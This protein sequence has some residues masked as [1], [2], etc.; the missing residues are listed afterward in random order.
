MAITRVGGTNGGAA[1]AGAVTLTLPGGM[2]VDDLI[3]V[4]YGNG[5]NDA[6]NPTL[7]M[8]TAGYTNLLGSTLHGNNATNGDGSLAIFYKFH[9][10]SDTTAVCAA[11]G[12]GTDSASAAALQVF[13]GVSK[14]TPFEVTSTTATGT[15]GGDPNPPS[16]SSFTEAD[17]TVVI[18]GCVASATSPLTLTA[19][20]NYTTN[21]QNGT[22]TDTFSAST[23]LAYRLSGAADPEDPGVFTDSGTGGG[24][25]A[26]TMVLRP[27]R[28]TAQSIDATTTLT[29]AL[30]RA[31]GHSV[32]IAATTTL[33]TAL[34][35]S[36]GK[37]VAAASTLTAGLTATFVPGIPPVPKPI[38]EVGRRVFDSSYA[39]DETGVR[40]FGNGKNKVTGVGV[41]VFGPPTQ[42]IDVTTTISPSIAA[43]KIPALVGWEGFDHSVKTASATANL[44]TKLW[45]TVNDVGGVITFVTGRDGV[46]KAVQL[47]VNGTNT[48]EMRRNLAVGSTSLVVSMYVKLVGGVAPTGASLRVFQATCDSVGLLSIT[49][50]GFLVAAYSTG[51]G[52]H[53]SS[54]GFDMR[55]GNWHRVDAYYNTSPA[56]HTVDWYVDG[57]A[58]DQAFSTL[59]AASNIT[60][61]AFGTNLA[62]STGTIQLDDAVWSQTS[63]NNPIGPHTV[64]SAV[65][66]DDNAESVYGTNVMEQGNGTDL[67]SSNKAYQ[68]LDEWPPTTGTNNADTVTQAAAGAGNFVSVEFGNTPNYVTTNALWG[69]SAVVAHQSDGTT[70]N[71]GTTKIVDGAGTSLTNV[72]SGDMSE[73]TAHYTRANITAPA[74]GWT[75][76][77]FNNARAQLGF[78]TDSTTDPE[79][80]AIMLTGVTVDVPSS[81]TNTPQSIDVTST[82]VAALTK[83]I[84]KAVAATSTIAPALTRAVLKPIAA[85]TALTVSLTKNIGKSIAPTLT[86]AVALVAQKTVQKAIAATTTFT[87]ALTK[88]VGKPIAATTTLTVAI[89]KRVG[90]TIA[91]TVTMTVALTKSVGKLIAVTTTFV[92]ALTRRVG[93]LIAITL[94]MTVALTA[95]K[96]VQRAI[97]VT[98]TLTA[99]ISRRVGKLVP[100]TTTLT[101]AMVRNVGKLVA[102]SVPFTVALTKQSYELIAATT[103]FVVSLTKRVGK[104]IP[105]T[106]TITAVVSAHIAITRT[107]SATTT[108]AVSLTKNV[109]KLVPVTTALTVAMVR[110]VGKAIAVT[111]TLLVSLTR[112]MFETVA[113]TTSLLVSLVRRTSKTIAPTLT[114]AVALTAQKT[115]QK[116][117]AVTTTLAVSLTK[118][119]PKAI[120]PALTLTVALVRRT[121]KTFDIVVSFAVAI[122]KRVAKSI[123]PTLT[124]AVSITS[125]KVKTVAIAATTTVVAAVRRN[126]GKLVATTSTVVASLSRQTPVSVAAA[127]S[128]VVS[129]TRR[130]SKTVATTTTFA[131]SLTKTITERIAATT[132]FVVTVSAIKVLARAINVTTTITVALSRRTGKNIAAATTFAVSLVKKL[133]LTKAID[134]G[135]TFAVSIRTGVR[136]LI[137]VAV[138]FTVSL[139]KRIPKAIA[140]G[141][142]VAVTIA[143]GAN[144]FA[145]IAVNVLFAVGVNAFKELHSAFQKSIDV[146]LT[147]TVHI[148]RGIGHRI[149]VTT[150]LIAHAFSRLK[151]FVWPPTGLPTD[152]WV[153]DEEDLEFEEWP[154]SQGTEDDEWT[155]VH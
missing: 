98:T 131:V 6:T 123:A 119:I 117:I 59:T 32:A 72:Y 151:E 46:G 90:K 146:S 64:F 25:A 94:T 136:K 28:V 109:G 47:A 38:D 41:R 116:L 49:T 45:D 9:N 43:T 66:S 100:V 120:A 91:A 132:T 127:S 108:L 2:A 80:L 79:W 73:T 97:D 138:P 143:K 55:D 154:I 83:N 15:T 4:A 1:N 60:V 150:T 75:K 89:T 52:I 141:V 21:A 54:P 130:T 134:V 99:A 92:V 36:V 81:G 122:T 106:A 101:V 13:R 20:T 145:V 95:Q 3:I 33:T 18:A 121:S 113:V 71:N 103:T 144:R 133:T 22:G 67:S 40:V 84:G 7:T 129:M 42:Y 142:S 115:V 51:T 140:V 88:N 86:F 37:L 48:C 135:V 128:L 17:C 26:V 57:A 14:G 76:D 125:T 107:I 50:G 5:D 96:T 19:P 93:K 68:Y 69:V 11:G 104:T 65:P 149:A 53:V 35:R 112:R 148:R 39:L 139:T 110:N 155:G 118:N 30:T 12:T 137:E 61:M 126:T 152:G 44:G 56:V 16:I 111:T 63:A 102:V 23:G 147:M 114:L 70:A 8:T 74:G 27:A 153:L 77:G 87:V 62:T 24:W 29:P 105:V 58:Q 85:T 78:S 124:L 34:A 10:G 31:V 82:L